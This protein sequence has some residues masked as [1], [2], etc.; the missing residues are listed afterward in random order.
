MKEAAHRT[1]NYMY[2]FFS[3]QSIST[4]LINFDQVGSFP[5]RHS[6][7][8]ENAES[9][10]EEEEKKVILR[11][12]IKTRRL[13]NLL[14]RSRHRHTF[15]H[16]H[17]HNKE[18]ARCWLAAWFR[19]RG[20]AQLTNQV[21]PRPRSLIHCRPHKSRALRT[22][23]S[24]MDPRESQTLPSA[25]LLKSTPKTFKSSPLVLHFCDPATLINAS[26]LIFSPLPQSR[27]P[28]HPH[29]RS[30]QKKKKRITKNRF[31]APP[32]TPSTTIL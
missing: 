16:T 25:H 22:H 1:R 12:M 20:A 29:P 18:Q 3:S 30:I 19:S 11:Q 26:P 2:L 15:T 9:T 10:E 28:R 23:W 5:K 4:W 24:A 31:H 6:S 21:D 14:E 17:T 27:N 8:L 7:R 13:R 32:R